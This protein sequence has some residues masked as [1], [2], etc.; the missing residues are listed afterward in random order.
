MTQL[1]ESG[2]SVLLETAFVPSAWFCG[3]DWEFDEWLLL[4]E[5]VDE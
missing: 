2:D 3:L 1:W 5:Q 4:S